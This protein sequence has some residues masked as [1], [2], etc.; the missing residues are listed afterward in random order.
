MAHITIGSWNCKQLGEQTPISRP[1]VLPNISEVII[2]EQV[3]I[4]ALQEVFND[5][6]PRSLCELLTSQ[7]PWEWAYYSY[8]E[9]Y[10]IEKEYSIIW[11]ATK[12]TIRKENELDIVRKKLKKLE[13]D[14]FSYPPQYTSFE[15]ANAPMT[16]LRLI[17]V[18][19]TTQAKS[20]SDDTKN[21]ATTEFDTLVDRIYGNLSTTSLGDSK[22]PYTVILG[23]YNLAYI[24]CLRTKFVTHISDP[25][26]IS[27]ERYVNDF[28]HFSHCE[29]LQEKISVPNIKRIDTVQKYFRDSENP[30]NQHLREMSDHVPIVM[31]IDLA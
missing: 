19:L 5:V 15:L 1:K 21:N 8:G 6:I 31:Q 25:T 10:V 3:D 20:N 12:F 7:T 14:T 29:E 2:Q 18:H 30:Y 28:D 4:I 13:S 22:V 24:D 26:T 11:N 23:D 17:N 27:S 9:D 16:D